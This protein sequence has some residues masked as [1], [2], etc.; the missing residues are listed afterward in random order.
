MLPFGQIENC[1]LQLAAVDKRRHVALDQAGGV[2]LNVVKRQRGVGRVD[3]AVVAVFAP[4]GGAVPGA[5]LGF[6]RG[7]CVGGHIQPGT[8]GKFTQVMQVGGQGHPA[9]GMKWVVAGNRG[10]GKSSTGK[11][12]AERSGNWGV[13]KSVS[14]QLCALFHKNTGGFSKAKASGMGRVASGLHMCGVAGEKV[15]G[16]GAIVVRATPCRACGKLARCYFFRSC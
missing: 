12:K 4:R 7:Q 6:V 16:D 14:C 10:H 8:L 15:E 1:C 9:R 3:V 2:A 13:A 11:R 5:V